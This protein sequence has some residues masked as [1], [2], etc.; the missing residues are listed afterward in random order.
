MR[1][2][3]QLLVIVYFKQDVSHKFEEREP[4]LRKFAKEYK[5]MAQFLRVDCD[6]FPDKIKQ[7]KL[8]GNIDN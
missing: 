5:D 8:P 6:N 4:A 3:D 7:E 1:N 2:T